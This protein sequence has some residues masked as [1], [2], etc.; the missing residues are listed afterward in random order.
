[1]T[2]VREVRKWSRWV[3][4]L[5]QLVSTYRSPPLGERKQ[6]TKLKTKM[7]SP[8]IHSEENTSMVMVI[9]HTFLPCPGYTRATCIV[10]HRNG[11][12]QTMETRTFQQ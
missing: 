7:A 4:P 11:L 10:L 2:G 9:T 8:P 12:V 1:M 5:V 3:P 6:K